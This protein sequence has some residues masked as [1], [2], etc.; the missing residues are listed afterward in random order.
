[1]LLHSDLSTSNHTTFDIAK[2]QTT[3]VLVF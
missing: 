3:S 1:L 2:A